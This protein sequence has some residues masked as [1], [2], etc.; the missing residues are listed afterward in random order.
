MAEARRPE[1]SAVDS[2]D[3]FK[4][5]GPEPPENDSGPSPS[6]DDARLEQPRAHAN[7]EATRTPNHPGVASTW[8]QE[9]RDERNA[10]DILRTSK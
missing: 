2:D 9:S 8:Q 7:R 6:V 5:H 1:Q 4:R 10:A 3:T